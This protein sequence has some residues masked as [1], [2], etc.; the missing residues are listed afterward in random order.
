MPSYMEYCSYIYFFGS[1]IYGPTFE[2]MEY[3]N[4]IEKKGK[5]KEIPNGFSACLK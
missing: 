5:Y 1:T 2:F 3:K 4:F